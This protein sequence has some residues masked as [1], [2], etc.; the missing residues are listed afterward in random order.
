[1]CK[2]FIC[3]CSYKDLP[4][5]PLSCSYDGNLKDLLAYNKPKSSK[6]LF[7]QKIQMNINDLESKRQFKCNVVRN[8]CLI[9][10]RCML[11]VRYSIGLARLS[12]GEGV[13]FIRR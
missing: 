11:M 2:D 6:K 7:Y 3:V 13:D 12:R 10:S 5:N 9:H 8:S 4:G 1:M